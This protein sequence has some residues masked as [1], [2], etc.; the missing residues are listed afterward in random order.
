MRTTVDLPDDLY[1]QAKSKAAIDGVRV[2]DLIEDGLR[3]V[4]GL[5]GKSKS[6][7]ARFPLKKSHRPGALSTDDVRAA[8]ADAARVED[9]GRAG[10]V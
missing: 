6:R 5:P 1:R 3:R 10:L 7:R 2:R 4:L 8:E 9:R